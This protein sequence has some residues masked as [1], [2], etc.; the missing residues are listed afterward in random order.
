MGL[1]TTY[2]FKDIII[3]NTYIRINGIYAEKVTVENVSKFI[4]RLTVG[5]LSP[6]KE[7]LLEQFYHNIEFNPSEIGNPYAFGYSKLK[8]LAEF[9]GA[10]DD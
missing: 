2:N 7:N 6:N 8:E 5:V 9:S 1:K 3:E 4:L 10:I